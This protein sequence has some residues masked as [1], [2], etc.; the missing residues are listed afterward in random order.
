M[1]AKTKVFLSC[2]LYQILNELSK[3]ENKTHEQR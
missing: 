2:S 3:Q 1:N